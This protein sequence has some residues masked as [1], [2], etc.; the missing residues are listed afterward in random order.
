MFSMMNYLRLQLRISAFTNL[1]VMCMIRMRQCYKPSVDLDINLVHTA[2]WRAT[3]QV[4]SIIIA[5][6]HYFF[7][8]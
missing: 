1:C 3:A 5:V 8:V 6:V 7:F 2:H 4:F